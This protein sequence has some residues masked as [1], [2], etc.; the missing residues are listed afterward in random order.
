MY[1][2]APAG[3]R[4]LAG[5]GRLERPVGPRWSRK[6][7]FGVALSEC[8]YR[9]EPRAFQ[10]RRATARLQ[11]ICRVQLQ[12]WALR[13][14]SSFDASGHVRVVANDSTA[15]PSGKNFLGIRSQGMALTVL[16]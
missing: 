10:V 5:A 7:G 1:V 11:E 6:R 4:C 8:D 3:L 2:L 13:V 16:R 15:R 12:R 14:G 9:G